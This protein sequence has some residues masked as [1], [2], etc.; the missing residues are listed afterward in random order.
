MIALG[1]DYGYLKALHLVGVVCWFAGLFYIVRLFI[2]HTEAKRDES[3]EDFKIIDRYLSTMERRL[4]YGITVPAMVITTV[5]GLWL[6]VE[7]KAFAE[8][9]FWLKGVLL[10]GLFIYHFSCGRLR[11]QISEQSYTKTS[12][13]LRI[14]NEGATFYLLT[15]V[16]LA[17]TKDLMAPLWA[18]LGFL[19]L[20]AV[21]LTFL[22]VRASRL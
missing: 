7:T 21:V 22:R 2:Y 1:M 5:F 8:P 16:F 13:Q 4:W 9:W 10:L 15:I 12:R 18:M 6:T 3:A 14:K 19:L 20:V 17:V 11:K